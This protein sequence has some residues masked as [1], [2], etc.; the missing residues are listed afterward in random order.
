ML[1]ASPGTNSGTVLWDQLSVGAG[2]PSTSKQRPPD[3]YLRIDLVSSTFHSLLGHCSLALKTNTGCSVSLPHPDSVLRAFNIARDT[4]FVDFSSVG[5]LVS[6]V[7]SLS[8]YGL[9]RVFLTVIRS[10]FAQ[11]HHQPADPTNPAQGNINPAISRS[12][13][14]M[15]LHPPRRHVESRRVACCRKH[16]CSA[17]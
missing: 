17:E 4:A 15:Q 1:T 2:T 7:S 6:P 16:S 12:W 10:A 9:P 11:D 8:R 14:R 5:H 13:Q 3:V